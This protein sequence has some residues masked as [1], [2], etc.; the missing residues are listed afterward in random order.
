MFLSCSSGK[1]SVPVLWDKVEKTIVNNESSEIVEMMNSEFNAWATNSELNLSP[2]HLKEKMMEINS[3]VYPTINNGVYRCG[4]A[5]SQQAY[6]E[7][8]V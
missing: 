8:F 2:E 5:K 3:W 1:Y 4:F 6:E 7:A